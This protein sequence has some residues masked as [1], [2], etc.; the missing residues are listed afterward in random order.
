MLIIKIVAA[1]I[2]LFL[3]DVDRRR[4][5]ESHTSAPRRRTL[6]QLKSTTT[7]TVPKKKRR[8]EYGN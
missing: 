5:C 7:L 4:M 3:N 8:R 2:I 6:L 1:K